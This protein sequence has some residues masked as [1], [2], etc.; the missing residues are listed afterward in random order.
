MC[1]L[2]LDTVGQQ[3]PPG[4]PGPKGRA[5]LTGHTG[6]QGPPGADGA[7]GPA[8]PQGSPG[9]E[10]SRGPPGVDAIAAGGGALYV[11]WGNTSCPSTEG[12]KKVYSGIAGGTYTDWNGGSASY[13][14]MMKEEEIALTFRA[15]KQS[16]ARMYG[17]EY[18]YP[19]L[20]THNGNVPCA[21]CYVPAR[22]TLLMLPAKANCP[23]TW[24]K[25]YFGYLMSGRDNH[26]RTTAVCVDAS[27]QSFIGS[28][29]DTNGALFAHI[30]VECKR[31][32]PCP[33]YRDEQELNC[34]VCTK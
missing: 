4:D 6:P 34:V 5:G 12:T 22:S 32:L 30:E 23:P 33:P 7:A 24:T 17:A 31:G 18:E 9:D 1:I 29:C 20:G 8:G 16:Y 19:I 2:Y 11:R 26:R 14:C 13:E 21:M 3:G 27:M 15:G 10:G 25:E 28:E